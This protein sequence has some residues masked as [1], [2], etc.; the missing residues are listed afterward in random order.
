MGDDGGI[1]KRGGFQRVF[2]GEESADEELSWSGKRVLVDDVGNHFMV[3]FQQ[4][5]FDVEVS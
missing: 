3:V 5:S 1:E 4:L 2:A